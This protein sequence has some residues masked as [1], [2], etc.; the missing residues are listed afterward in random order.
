MHTCSCMREH[1]VCDKHYFNEHACVTHPKLTALNSYGSCFDQALLINYILRTLYKANSRF[2]YLEFRDGSRHA[3]NVFHNRN[4][5]LFYLADT[6]LK[7]DKTVVTLGRSW[8]EAIPVMLNAIATNKG[9]II[10]YSKELD[11][12]KLYR[13][14]IPICDFFKLTGTTLTQKH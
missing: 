12:R 3:T 10:S 1:Q 14:N 4:T 2:Y 11:V 8:K 5:K 13:E 9:S 6:C 7:L